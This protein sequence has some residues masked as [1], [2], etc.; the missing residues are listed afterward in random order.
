MNLKYV[1][2]HSI[3][4]FL[5]AYVITFHNA[6]YVLWEAD[7]T[8]TVFISIAVYV[9]FSIYM[10]VKGEKSNFEMIKSYGSMFPVF[11][12]FGSA[13]GMSYLFFSGAGIQ[14]V[15]ADQRMM[16]L[17]GEMS[18]VL[19]TVIIGIGLFVLLWLQ[20]SICFGKHDNE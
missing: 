16:Y 1:T 20:R 18:T 2:F 10:G 17:M 7:K 6:L 15:A 5:L 9:F 4:L 13:V 12:L 11:G 8:K 19:S 14:N 3:F